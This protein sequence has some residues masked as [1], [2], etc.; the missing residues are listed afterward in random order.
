M[1]PKSLTL[2]AILAAV[3]GLAVPAA[4]VKALGKESVDAT[5]TAHPYWCALGLA[6]Y[7]IGVGL[8]TF[9]RKVISHLDWPK[10][11]A[12]WLDG[13]ARRFLAFFGYRHK[14]LLRLC[15]RHRYS[16]GEGKLVRG[17]FL[18]DVEKLFVMLYVAPENPEDIKSSLLHRE[19]R[20]NGGTIWD[21]LA[22]KAPSHPFI[23]VY[24]D[25]GAGKTTLCQHVALVLAKGRQ[26]RFNRRCPRFLPALVLLR[27]YSILLTSD[28]PP[29]LADLLAQQENDSGMPAPEGWFQAKLRE[30]R[31]LIL[32]DG[33]DETGDDAA[34]SRLATWVEN[35]RQRY[36][37]NRFVITS[38]PHGY[39]SAAA[40]P[41]TVLQIQPFSFEQAEQLVTNW[42]EAESLLVGETNERARQKAVDLFKQIRASAPLAAL[43]VNPLLLRLIAV[44]H[45][46]S[47]EPLPLRRA[48]LYERICTVLISEWRKEKG[49]SAE[50]QA[51]AQCR[52]VLQS[53][54]LS[55]TQSNSLALPL[56]KALRSV[57]AFLRTA[58]LPSS[59]SA[60]ERL[61]HSIADSTNLLMLDVKSKECAFAHR[62]IQEYL[63]AYQARED[64]NDS[65]LISRIRESWWRDTII[66]YA[67]LGDASSLVKTMLK[68]PT[69]VE[70]IALAYEC[71]AQARIIDSS[72]RDEMDRIIINNLES[73]NLEAF[74]F[75]AEVILSLRVRRMLR[76]DGEAV[77]D[78][79]Y[80]SCAE[81]ELFLQTYDRNR[82]RYHQP[83]HWTAPRFPT[84]EALRPITGIRYADAEVFCEWLTDWAK[85]R[86]GG[87]FR[88][89]IPDEALR[90]ELA[91][92]EVDG[93]F[94]NLC[95]DIVGAWTQGEHNVIGI[96]PVDKD[97]WPR[98]SDIWRREEYLKWM[99]RHRNCVWEHVR[100]YRDWDLRLELDLGR[101]RDIDIAIGLNFPDRTHYENGPS[102][103]FIPERDRD[104][105][106]ARR[107]ALDDALYNFLS[108]FRSR[109]PRDVTRLDESIQ[110][111]CQ[112][113]EVFHWE[114]TSWAAGG[115][116]R[117]VRNA[118]RLRR[119]VGKG[120][121][122]KLRDVC[123][124]LV[125]QLL[126]LK[127]R[128][129]G[130]LPSWE[131]IR[132]VREPTRV[133]L[134]VIKMFFSSPLPKPF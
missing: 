87:K 105:G 42:Y 31:C 56:D 66:L 61:L 98:V 133:D 14:Y 81:Y 11:V 39:R 63:T 72:L 101:F 119:T 51:I 106:L 50:D 114:A 124:D 84:G 91:L 120:D 15:E 54:A 113:V 53:L 22:N 68:K 103:W 35:Q 6:A 112:A 128:L 110:L 49:Q 82:S 34:R 80:I 102:T 94:Q 129:E 75:S 36:S 65:L 130:D 21:F 26:R 107:K 73:P 74:L 19:L 10:A 16:T 12:D 95:S 5:L 70:A 111:L 33:L 93:P 52:H 58:K 71:V 78:N 79:S 117:R 27:K 57:R 122:A 9:G 32:L 23:A 100:I 44:V 89:P 20:Q 40:L 41:P 37:T 43:A 108:G 8:V 46:R 83:D 127:E 77:V 38:R 90:V 123:I 29:D 17:P 2:N 97:R 116:W 64:N 126:L 7:A 4:L 131:G 60:A 1:T 96:I 125:S 3:L 30:G 104:L 48:D 62:T 13:R 55:M 118:V 25:A 115:L 45:R 59:L 109:V 28:N 67:A 69:T 76:L 85:Q 132:V 88:L 121:Y 18:L 134:D 92:Q 24:G 47:E 86:G 99:E